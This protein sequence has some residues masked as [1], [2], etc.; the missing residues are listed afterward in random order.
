MGLFSKK[1][2]P[3]ASKA[4]QLE[5]QIAAV[6]LQ[7]KQLNRKLDEPESAAAPIPTPEV[8]KSRSNGHQRTHP[9][10]PL[11]STVAPRGP[12]AAQ[13]RNVPREPIFESVDQAAPAAQSDPSKAHFNDLG[14]RKYDLPGAWKRIVSVFRGPAT[15]NPKLVSYLA[16]GSI[17]GLRPLRYEKRVARN[18]FIMMSIFFVVV[19]YWATAVFWRHR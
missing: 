18:R 10:S 8:P 14:V 7:I 9:Q 5:Q 15:H 3:I 19:L 17:R 11:R 13:I 2:D 12:H 16:A 4:R 1:A 6:Q